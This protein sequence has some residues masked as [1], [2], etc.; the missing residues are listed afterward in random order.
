MGSDADIAIWDPEREFT[1]TAEAMHD[2]VGYT[3]YEGR[4]VK[5]FPTTVI[6]RGRVVVEDGKLHAEPG[7]G[8]FIPCD[9]PG[10]AQPAGR[11]SEAQALARRFGAHDVF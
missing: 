10:A 1:I 5:G 4:T 11:L 7:S 8:E 9:R 6:S 2:N 3:P